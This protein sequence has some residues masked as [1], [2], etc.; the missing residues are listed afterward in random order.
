MIIQIGITCVPWTSVDEDMVF[1]IFFFSNNVN[2]TL[3]FNLNL[4]FSV[5]KSNIPSKKCFEA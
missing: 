3:T 2:K 4:F 1:D 5:Q